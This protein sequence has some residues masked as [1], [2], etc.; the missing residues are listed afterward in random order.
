MRKSERQC[1]VSK[2][3]YE[4]KGVSR[5]GLILGYR[6]MQ[7]VKRQFNWSRREEDST[8]GRTVGKDKTVILTEVQRECQLTLN[9]TL[10]LT[11]S[12]DP[13]KN[14]FFGNILNSF[15]IEPTYLF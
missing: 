5:S 4:C 13:L 8:I 2:T 15:L 11:I 14:M 9:Q 6:L 3:R 12:S 1:L 10:V 7:T